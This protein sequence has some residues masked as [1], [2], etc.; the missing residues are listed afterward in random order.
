MYLVL[1]NRTRMYAWGGKSEFGVYLSQDSLQVVQGYNADCKVLG[2]HHSAEQHQIPLSSLASFSSYW[3]NIPAFSNTTT[4][5]N[6]IALIQCSNLF[7]Y[8]SA[9]NPVPSDAFLPEEHQTNI[10]SSHSMHQ[11]SALIFICYRLLI[12]QICIFSHFGLVNVF[13]I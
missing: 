8:P 5:F 9:H 4:L 2:C 7:L 10:T 11:W 6:T 1:Y 13:S 3:I 12:C